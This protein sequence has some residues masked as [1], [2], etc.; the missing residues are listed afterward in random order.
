MRTFLALIASL[1]LGA[2][3]GGIDSPP[4]VG[5]DNGGV[6][7]GGSG[8][9]AV[10][11]RKLFDDNVRPIIAA[12]CVACHSVA[13]PVG[14]I[15]GFVDTNATTAY[16][17]ATGYQALV[18]DWTV[19]APILTKLSTGT[20]MNASKGA[21]VVYSPTD[22]SNITG[23]LSKELE[24]RAGGTPPPVGTESAAEATVRLTKEWSG[25]MTLENF[26]AANMRAWGNVNAGGGGNCKTCHYNG[27][28]GNI[29]ENVDQPF[30]D[31]ISQDKY[32]MA[33]Y[34]SVDLSGGVP[35]AL[36]IV[37]T[38]SFTGVGTGLAP[39]QSHPRFDPDNNNGMAALQQFYTLTMTAKMA[40]PGGVCGP[41]KLLN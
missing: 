28:Y 7:G 22:I 27:E 20:H 8:S 35:T 3:V 40:A 2:C 23:W 1:G 37:N 32:Y 10:E 25:C 34:F 12:K 31:T 4:P 33:Q 11:A 36:V 41:P 18:G 16:E 9:A 38:R 30:F 26:T 21:D 17:T 29:A 6:G 24:A 13:G 39:H 14:N 15:T 5:D 19:S